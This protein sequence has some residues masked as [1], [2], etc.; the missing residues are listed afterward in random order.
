MRK[1]IN[2]YNNYCEQQRKIRI[3]EDATF[4]KSIYTDNTLFVQD[5]EEPKDI[6]YKRERKNKKQK[7]K[8]KKVN[9]KLHLPEP[10]KI[11]DIARLQWELEKDNRM[12]V[13]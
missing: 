1:I 12:R 7:R 5:F 4:M 2:K 10:M 11:M 13:Q 3:Q 9:N 6:G 8:N